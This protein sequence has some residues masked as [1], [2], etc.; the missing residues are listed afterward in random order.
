MQCS[1]Q[2]D[3]EPGVDIQDWGYINGTN[4]Q[5]F[6]SRPLADLTN[7]GHSHGDFSA[8][9][10]GGLMDGCTHG[11]DCYSFVRK[12][13]VQPY[14]DIATTYS[15][16]N[17]MFQTNEGPSFEAHQ[18]IFAGTSAPVGQTNQSYFDWFA[19]NNPGG[20]FNNA[21][22][23]SMDT[24]NN[25]DFVNGIKW[26]GTTKDGSSQHPWYIPPPPPPLNYSYPC[27]EHRTLSDLL[28]DH[29]NFLEILRAERRL[30]L[31]G[32]DCY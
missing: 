4:H 15:F 23:S 10:H 24:Q 28:D 21:G 13:D 14:F 18:F 1:G 19:L 30:D 25:E 6:V 8:M 11:T 29:G 16:A 20:F 7:P 3:F 22:C 5:C 9:Y 31:V 2:D 27:Y 12:S 26:D 32:A 17:Y